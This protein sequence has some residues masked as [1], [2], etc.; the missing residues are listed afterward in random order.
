MY[1]Y[2]AAAEDEISFDPDDIITHIEQ[3][4][5]YFI[6]INSIKM[7]IFIKDRR[8]LV[9]WIVQKQIWS[10]SS[11]LCS[12]SAINKIRLLRCGLNKSFLYDL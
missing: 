11:E 8:G 6:S 3:V 7:A 9:A 12:T 10:I 1:D 2:Q 5:Q 4:T